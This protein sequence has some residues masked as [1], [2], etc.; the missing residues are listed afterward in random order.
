MLS[1]FTGID[2]LA[3]EGRIADMNGGNDT[4]RTVIERLETVRNELLEI[5]LQPGRHWRM[6]AGLAGL[7]GLLAETIRQDDA[8]AAA[9]E[10]RPENTRPHLRVVPDDASR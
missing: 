1:I 5:T 2:G 6:V 9:R 10:S 3:N 4:G 8:S 7:T